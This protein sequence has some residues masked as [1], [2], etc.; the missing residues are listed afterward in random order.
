MPSFH[1]EQTDLSNQD[2]KALFKMADQIGKKRY[3]RLT[4]QDF[5]QYRRFDRWR[6]LGGDGE[7]GTTPESRRWVQENSDCLCPVCSQPFSQQGGKTI[8]HKLP[9]AQYPWLSMVFDNFWIICQQCNF[10]KG[11]KHWYEYERFIFEKYPDRYAD[12]QLFRPR[13]LLKTLESEDKL[14]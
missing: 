13:K 7:C 12:V 1:P 14:D 2:L 6:Y 11:E 8:D 4:Q 9:R 3:H 10:E 5:E